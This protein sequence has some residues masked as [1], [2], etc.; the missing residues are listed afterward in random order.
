MST[1]ADRKLAARLLC[2]GFAG[3][4]VDDSL[5]EMLRAGVSGVILF[6]RNA[7]THAGAG[8]WFVRSRANPLRL[9]IQNLCIDRP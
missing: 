1:D 5:R 4:V 6:A 3:T 8:S 7:T 9:E 2:V